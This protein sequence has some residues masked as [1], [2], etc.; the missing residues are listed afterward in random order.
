MA[1]F[2]KAVGICAVSEFM[3]RA[4]VITIEE[5]TEKG[6]PIITVG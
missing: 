1:L 5:S 2:L 4:Q 3:I 6:A